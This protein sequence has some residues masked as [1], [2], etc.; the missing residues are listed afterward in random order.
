MRLMIS[1]VAT[2]LIAA[3]PVFAENLFL[4]DTGAE[5]GI[6]FVTKGG[7]FQTLVPV[8]HDKEVFHEGKAS[9]RVD[10]NDKIFAGPPGV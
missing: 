4:G 2:L 1:A 10:W 5:A 9:L 7:M 8:F 3:S 6:E